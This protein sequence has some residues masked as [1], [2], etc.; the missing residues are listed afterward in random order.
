MSAVPAVLGRNARA[1]LP[2]RTPTPLYAPDPGV[3]RDATTTE[4][5]SVI[6]HLTSEPLVD[7]LGRS[8]HAA[9]ADRLLQ[10][11]GRGDP[12]AFGVL[13]DWTAPVI[14]GCLRGA[15]ADLAD[16]DEAKRLTETVY[17]DL[18]RS[19][20]QFDPRERSAHQRLLDFTRCELLRWHL[21]RRI[22]VCAQRSPTLRVVD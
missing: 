14:F 10:A 1:V 7:H 5:D 6:R 16:L 18:W 17:I 21:R 22:P 12:A 19:A 8:L 4:R 11:A 20:P 9:R 3:P 15:L 2:H 13:Y